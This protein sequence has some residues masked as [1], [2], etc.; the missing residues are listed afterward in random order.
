MSAFPYALEYPPVRL[1]RLPTLSHIQQITS[2][3]PDNDSQSSL[4][5]QMQ[6]CSSLCN[7]QLMGHVTIFWNLLTG[8]CLDTSTIIILLAEIPFGDLGCARSSFPSNHDS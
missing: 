5:W 8:P 3:H 2:Y 4:A 7:N 1:L 6:H